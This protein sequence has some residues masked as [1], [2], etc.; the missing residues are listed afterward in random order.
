M[1][2]CHIILSNEEKRFVMNYADLGLVSAATLMAK[3]LQGGYVVPAYNFVTSEH[4][5]AIARACLET[6]SPVILQASANARRYCP[7]PVLRHLVAGISEMLSAASPAL[8]AALNLDHGATPEECAEAIEDGFSSVMIDGSRLCFE[9][10]VRL[11]AEVV[12]YAHARGVS[13][14][15]E[16]GVLSGT[17]EDARVATSFFTEPAAAAEF[18]RRTG[19]DCLAVSVGNIHGLSK[20]APGAT[21]PALRF[22]LIEAIG[23]LLPDTPLVLHGSSSV[24]AAYARMLA[25][26]G[27]RAEGAQGIPEA[28]LRR[29][30]ATT[31]CKINIASD[32]FLVMTAVVRRQLATAPAA[33]D[34]R[35][36]LGPAREELVK[37]YAEKNRALFGSA[38]KG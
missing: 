22:D 3:A 30:A 34:P 37:L 8:P 10:N 4:A 26:N 24:P 25:E 27:G 2:F 23:R 17:E 11:T 16:L 28:E 32:G 14:E 1:S 21:V 18:V 38:G 5:Q 31:I 9:E 15:G 13:V 7:R 12:S 29:A 19:V 20:I 33:I 6:R 35:T 36:Y